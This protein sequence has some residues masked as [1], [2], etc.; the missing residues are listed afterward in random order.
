MN[1]K[2]NDDEL[3][4]VNGGADVFAPNEPGTP[5]SELIGP[6]VGDDED[7]P[8]GGGP[9][10]HRDGGDNTDI[11]GGGGSDTFNQG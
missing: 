11:G 10:V 4:N 7:P 2:L 1:R 6:N 3:E 8:I 5:P 9:G